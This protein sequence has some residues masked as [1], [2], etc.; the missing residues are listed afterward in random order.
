M[1][2]LTQIDWAIAIIDMA[3][4]SMMPII[5]TTPMDM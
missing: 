1:C 5:Y 4:E 3:L 2:F